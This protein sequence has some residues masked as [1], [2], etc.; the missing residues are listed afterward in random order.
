M[1][2]CVA[3]LEL[4]I[5]GV[6]V[7]IHIALLWSYQKTWIRRRES[8][9]TFP[10]L[11]GIRPLATSYDSF[12]VT[13][14]LHARYLLRLVLESGCQLDRP[15][16]SETF[17]R[18]QTNSSPT[19]PD[20]QCRHESCVVPTFDTGE[21]KPIISSGSNDPASRRC[22]YCLAGRLR[23]ISSMEVLCADQPIF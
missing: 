8:F 11:P 15:R 16:T 4:R 20:L 5:S 14:M 17:S 23:Q 3:P 22:P 19:Q 6:R 7:S 10:V 12:L 2:R 21:E 1:R 18:L 9:A 13:T